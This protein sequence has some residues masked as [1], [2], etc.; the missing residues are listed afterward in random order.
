LDVHGYL[1][2]PVEGPELADAVRTVH[3]GEVCLAPE[4]ARRLAASDAPAAH[5]SRPT[6]RETEVLGLVVEGLGNRRIA[7]RLSISERT[8]ECHVTRLL[9]KFGADSRARLIRLALQQGW[10]T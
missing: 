7:A 2:K 5:G 8:V 9:A 6:S 4:V 10:V 3:G 1:C